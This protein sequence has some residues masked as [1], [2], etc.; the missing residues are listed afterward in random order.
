[1]K[2]AAITS[3]EYHWRKSSRS[4]DSGGNCVE[5]GCVHD[6]YWRKSTR[7]TQN[8]QCLEAANLADSIAV[9]DSKLPTTGDFPT[10]T[11]TPDDWTAV[12]V[13]VRD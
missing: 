5:V 9:R 4:N 12:L 13:T 1:M 6:A 7:S 10:L 8:G 2:T 11:M 3:F